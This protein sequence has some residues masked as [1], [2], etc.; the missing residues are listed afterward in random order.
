VDTLFEAWSNKKRREQILKVAEIRKKKL[1]DEFKQCMLFNASVY[2][3][4][5]LKNT[6]YVQ[7]QGKSRLRLPARS[8]TPP[9]PK[10]EPIPYP[11]SIQE[12]KL[13]NIEPTIIHTHGRYGDRIILKHD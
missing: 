5:E 12:P 9:L 11:I 3:L 4:M 8:L 6:P 10:L 13:V 2:G 7:E 1:E